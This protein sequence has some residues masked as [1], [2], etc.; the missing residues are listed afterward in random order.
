MLAGMRS[1]RST[2]GMVLLAI[3]L[4][5]A[6]FLVGVMIFAHVVGRTTS[7]PPRAEPPE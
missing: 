1:G 7:I 5:V 2:A 3:V 4:L 6:G